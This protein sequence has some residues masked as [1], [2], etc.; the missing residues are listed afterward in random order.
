[1]SILLAVTLFTLMSAMNVVYASVAE[2][3][4]HR[5]VMHKPVKWFM[6]PYKAHDGTHHGS[7]SGL[8]YHF[9]GTQNIEKVTMAW[10]N[11]FAIIAL[12]IVPFFT[13]S[14]TL[15]FFGWEFGAWMILGSA[16]AV[17]LGYYIAYEYSHWCM[18]VPKGRWFEN[19][20]FFRWLNGHHILHHRYVTKNFNV[21]LPIADFLFG[22]LITRSKV[23]FAQV[24]GP[25]VPDLQPL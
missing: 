5:Y 24:T 11:G 19:T 20:W 17:F 2:W 4:L 6:Y 14:M 21:V 7:F 18:H 16:F 3:L 12:A 13:I 23:R 9:D 25:S 10:W 1:M 15:Y 8:Q 22:T